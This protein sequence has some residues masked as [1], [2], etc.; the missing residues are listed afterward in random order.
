MLDESTTTGSA[1]CVL[2][3]GYI[4]RFG[5]G[6]AGRAGRAH[7]VAWEAM[8]GPVGPGLDLHH[9]CENPACVN[10]AHLVPMTRKQHAALHAL[11]RTHCPHGH[12]FDAENTY[13]RPDGGRQCRAC[14]RA[15]KARSFKGKAA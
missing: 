13:V 6:R 9:V 3:T 12:L 11:S 5:Y 2:H 8:H 7:R 1:A 10:V 14:E 15:R 4:D